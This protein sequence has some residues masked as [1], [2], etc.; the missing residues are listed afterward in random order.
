MY[1]HSVKGVISFEL[2]VSNVFSNIMQ[3]LA[4]LMHLS[5]GDMLTR[6]AHPKVHFQVYLILIFHPS[7]KS[8]VTKKLNCESVILK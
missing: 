8:L 6:Q 3:I 7:T 1:S 4:S 2:S 5:T